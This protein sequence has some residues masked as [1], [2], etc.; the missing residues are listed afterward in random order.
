MSVTESRDDGCLIW[1]VSSVV[2]TF[3]IWV[4]QCDYE[5]QSQVHEVDTETLVEAS[6]FANL[7]EPS[8]TCADLRGLS[9]T[10]RGPLADLRGP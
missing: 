3:L 9:R 4:H 1:V 5:L 2:M 10:T 8:R 7:G 6:I